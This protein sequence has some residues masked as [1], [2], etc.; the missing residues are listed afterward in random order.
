[1]RISLFHGLYKIL[2]APSIVLCSSEM[3]R[4]RSLVGT[5][6]CWVSKSIS[7]DKSRVALTDMDSGKPL[8]LLTYSAELLCSCNRLPESV[9][10]EQ[11]R[12]SVSELFISLLKSKFK[13]DADFL[14]AVIFPFFNDTTIV[15][16]E[17]V[18]E[19]EYEG[20]VNSMIQASDCYNFSNQSNLLYPNKNR[21][22]MAHKTKMGAIYI[23]TRK[24]WRGV[25]CKC[26]EA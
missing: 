11:T 25:R 3:K 1:M 12:L 14:F 2:H 21:Y 18:L 24:F 15:A 23:M 6:E 4:H 13:P 20:E 10:E 9:I 8:V 17:E 19:Q 22:S 5:G 26:V 7:K 16:E